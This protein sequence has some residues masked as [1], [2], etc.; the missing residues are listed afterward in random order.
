[1]AISGTQVPF[2]LSHGYRVVARDRRGHRRSSQIDTGHDMDHCAANAAAV[3]RH[4]N[5]RSAVHTGHST[6]GGEVARYVTDLVS[7]RAVW[8]RLCW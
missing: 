7:R 8:P 6:G 4:L 3:A 2:F 1:V 5:L